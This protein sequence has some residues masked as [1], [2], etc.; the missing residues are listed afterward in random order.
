MGYL[1]VVN[2]DVARKAE[3]ISDLLGKTRLKLATL[4]AVYAK[5]KEDPE[6]ADGLL[7]L[8]TDVAMTTERHRTL[9]EV[10]DLLTEE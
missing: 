10:L 4:R 8:A 1:R 3:E 9:V 7:Q 2:G 6:P 5:M